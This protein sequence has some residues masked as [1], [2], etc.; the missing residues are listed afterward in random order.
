M[1]FKFVAGNNINKV[2]LKSKFFLNRKTIPIINYISEN[3]INNSNKNFIEYQK[4]IHNIND[5]YIIALKLSSLN[6]ERRNINKICELCQTKNI[7]LII[8]AENNK[9]IKKYREITNSLLMKH[10][11][12]NLNIIKTYQMYRKD[13]ILELYDDLKF[14]SLNNSFF[15]AKLVR[16]AYWYEDKNT[17]NLYIKK[18]DTDINYNLAILKCYESNYNNHIIATHNHRSISLAT[19]VG[20]KN[21]KFIIANL[22]GMNQKYMK[23][24]NH[25]KAIYIPYGPYLEMLPYLSRRLYENYDQ[26]KYLN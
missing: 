21:N 11:K 18:E 25:K 7:K 12:N 19:K 4:L 6:F 8:D 24:I 1:L 23:N 3:N 16:G 5:N 22:L 13:S 20:L 15:S 2:I 26:I 10:N 14:A 9:N 17:S